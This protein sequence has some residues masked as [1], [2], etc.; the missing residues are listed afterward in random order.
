MLFAACGK[1]GNGQFDTPESTF[2]T[3]QQAIQNKDL[4]L[5]AQCWDPERLEREGS[6]SMLQEKPKLWEELQGM[7]Q[8]PQTL[9]KGKR[10]QSADGREK[11]KFE[12]DAPEAK[13][14]GIGS[15]IM[16]LNGENWQMYSW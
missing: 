13:G 3:L 11:L 6:Y 4:K 16:I 1:Q 2:L 14:G 8:G 12:V 9:G 15:M 5:Y 10:S 7:F